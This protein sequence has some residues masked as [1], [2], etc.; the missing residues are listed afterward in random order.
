MF[1]LLTDQSI[2]EVTLSECHICLRTLNDC[3]TNN[4]F[5]YEKTDS[6]SCVA[7]PRVMLDAMSSQLLLSAACHMAEPQTPGDKKVNKIVTSVTL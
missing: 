1:A 4:I 2:R 6:Q 5:Y 7:V 3:M